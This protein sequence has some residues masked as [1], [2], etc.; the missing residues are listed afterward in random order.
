M[1]KR[2]EMDFAER[3]PL[4]R[5]KESKRIELLNFY[6]KAMTKVKFSRENV[7]T[8]KDKTDKGEKIRGTDTLHKRN[9][10]QEKMFEYFKK[11]D[12]QAEVPLMKKSDSSYL[13]KR[14]ELF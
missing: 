10:K 3:I 11:K 6:N 9:S 13:R 14:F 4:E 12:L 2:S 5:I 1:R 8:Q 7:Y